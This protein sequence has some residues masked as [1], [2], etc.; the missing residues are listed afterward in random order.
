[1]AWWSKKDESILIKMEDYENTLNFSYLSYFLNSGT[2]WHSQSGKLLSCN[3]T[4]N[5]Q[6]FLNLMNYWK[7]NLVQNDGWQEFELYQFICSDNEHTWN[8]YY[9]VYITKWQFLQKDICIYIDNNV[10]LR[11]LIRFML[12]VTFSSNLLNS[13]WQDLLWV[14]YNFSV[15]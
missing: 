14:P 5:E 12:L 9:C 13:Y 8:V 11:T 1:M 3:C 10:F 4:K 6:N 7:P 2:F 15:S